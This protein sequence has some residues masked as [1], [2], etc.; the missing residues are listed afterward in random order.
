YLSRL[1][2]IDEFSDE[3]YSTPMAQF[4]LRL[5][6]A[7]KLYGDA[8]DLISFVQPG[9]VDLV[10]GVDRRIFGSAESTLWMQQSLAHF[11]R[12]SAN[13]NVFPGTAIAEVPS[14]ARAFL[15]NTADY[16]CRYK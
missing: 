14:G 7:I 6:Q 3:V 8:P 1:V 9:I 13:P 12:D 10:R 2:P 15:D 11:D 16:K 5:R 4:D